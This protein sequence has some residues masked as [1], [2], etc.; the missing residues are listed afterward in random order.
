MNDRVIGDQVIGDQGQSSIGSGQ[1]S[2]IGVGSNHHAHTP[3]TQISRSHG[4]TVSR[5]HS[6]AH[7]SYFLTVLWSPKPLTWN[8][9]PFNVRRRLTLLQLRI[10]PL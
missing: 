3:D 6:F 1:S 9:I 2:V 4:L 10:F 7:T 8:I 5:P